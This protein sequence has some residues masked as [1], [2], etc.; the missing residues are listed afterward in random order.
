MAIC[1]GCHVML[2]LVRCTIRA[3]YG[4]V[5]AVEWCMLTGKTTVLKHILENGSMKVACLV[6]DVASINI[7]AKLIRNKSKNTEQDKSQTAV[8]DMVELQNGCACT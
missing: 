6:N 8:A 2:L 4:Q 1:Y 3:A 7:D 5:S